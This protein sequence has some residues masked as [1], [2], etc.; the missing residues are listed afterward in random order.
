MSLIIFFGLCGW[1]NKN[2]KI[3]KNKNGIVGNFAYCKNK[4]EFY[5]LNYN[6]D[7]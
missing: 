4:K 5:G 6:L 2:D 7:S 1:K 3:C